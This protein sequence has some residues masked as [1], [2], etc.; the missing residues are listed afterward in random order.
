MIMVQWYHGTI[1]CL[2]D[3]A[4]NL[5][6]GTFTGLIVLVSWV[7]YCSMTIDEKV[8]F[9]ELGLVLQPDH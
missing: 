2:Q 3:R 1:I 7:W 4:L 9:G 5:V 6:V 8:I